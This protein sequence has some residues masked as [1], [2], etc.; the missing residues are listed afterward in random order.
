MLTPVKLN[1]RSFKI[2][3]FAITKKHRELHLNLESVMSE[4]GGRCLLY[5]GKGSTIG[6]IVEWFDK[7]IWVLP[8]QL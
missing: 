2:A 4:I 1:A 7:E 5:P 6:E 8:V 3:A